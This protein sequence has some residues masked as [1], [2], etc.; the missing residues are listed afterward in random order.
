M[1]ATVFKPHPNNVTTTLAGAYA[2]GSGSLVLAAGT[3]AAFGTAFPLNVT[4]AAIGSYGTPSEVETIF[5]VT[6]RATDTLTGVAAAEGTTD[7]AYAVGDRVDVRWTSGLAT[8]LEAAVNALENAVQPTGLPTQLIVNQGTLTAQLNT[9]QT[10]VTWNNASA[11]FVHWYGSVTDT[12][13]S[14]GSWL[15]Y[16]L[17]GGVAK[18][19][20]DKT[21]HVKAGAADAAFIDSGTVSATRLAGGSFTSG[22]WLRGDSTWQP[23]IVTKS[24]VAPSYNVLATDGLVL[25]DATSGGLT[26]QLPTATS[27][28]ANGTHEFIFW[29]TDAGANAIWVTVAGTDVVNPGGANHYAIPTGQGKYVRLVPTA[30]AGQ[31]GWWWITGSN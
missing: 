22:T 28:S 27:V 23:L 1:P 4:A 9:I 14:A 11:N 10:S 15:Q 17:V 18:W 29:R 13:S 12:A 21:G 30:P 26:I 20:I 3:G 8:A 19:A 5:T 31:P 24:V 7:R 16:M 2:A 6:G 25:C